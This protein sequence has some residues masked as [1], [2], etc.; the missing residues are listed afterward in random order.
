MLKEEGYQFMGA[1]FEAG[2]GDVRGSE[3]LPP[4]LSARGPDD[5]IRR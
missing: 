3:M 2:R 5:S 4:A 1:A